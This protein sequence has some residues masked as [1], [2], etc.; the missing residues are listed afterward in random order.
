MS[1][2]DTINPVFTTHGAISWTE[3]MTTDVD[4][5]KKFYEA[6][7]D[8]KIKDMPMPD[9]N[10]TYTCVRT[11]VQGEKDGIGGIMPMPPE[12]PAGVPP[13]WTP[14]VTVDS[15]DAAVDKVTE[16]GGEVVMPPLDVKGVGRMAWIKDPQGA[17]IAVMTYA[18]E[19]C[20]D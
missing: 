17:V 5:A 6:V 13:S 15:V 8:W 10:G 19:D 16:L 3:L 1:E 9:G 4:A 20:E 11:A 12:V 14:Y 7:F 2:V 18:M